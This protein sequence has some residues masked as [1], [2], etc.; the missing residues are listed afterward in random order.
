MKVEIRA[1]GAVIEGYVNAVD[2]DSRVIPTPVGGFVERVVPKTFERA[3][4]KGNDIKLKFNHGR[5]IGSVSAG[6]LE[7]KEDNIGLYAKAH[8]SDKEV[9]DRARKG[10]LR[11]WSFG[12]YKDKDRMEDLGNGL[13]RRYLEEIELNEISIISNGPLLPI[14][15]ATSIEMRGKEEAMSELR[16]ME[17]AAELKDLT[18]VE[19]PDYTELRSEIMLLRKRYAE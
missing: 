15:P 1:E 14:Y 3:L 9:I 4:T 6:T 11:G 2:R 19:S 17:D 7:L 8:V 13:K 12:F 5:E 16:G 18:P 10:E